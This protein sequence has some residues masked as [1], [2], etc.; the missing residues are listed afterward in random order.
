MIAVGSGGTLLAGQLILNHVS[1]AIGSDSLLPAGSGNQP[2]SEVT[3]PLN[4]LLAGLDYRAGDA[5]SETNQRAD[6]V[7]WVHIPRE[8]DRAYIV[9]LPRDLVVDIPAFPAAK[10]QGEKGGRLNASFAAGM[11]NKMGR[12]G[13]MQLLT[14]TVEQLTGVKFDMAGVIDWYGFTGITHELG[15]V[16]MCLD[17]GFKSTQPGFKNFTFD[18]GC[19]HYDEHKALALVRQRYDVEGGDYGR[20]K[21]QQQFI[22]QILKQATS[23][24][25]LS[26][27]LKLNAIIKSVGAS[28]KIDFGAYDFADLLWALKGITPD[29]LLTMRIPSS[30][31]G[32]ENNYG[33]EALNPQ[34]GPEMFRA[35]ADERIE[36]F[37]ASHPELA[38]RL[39]A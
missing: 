28:L 24:D 29:N 33:G 16:T 21:L 27:P 19:N 9:S 10:F 23:K 5:D 17:K 4:I 34:L 13:G 2:R 11:Q 37:L 6:S 1:D 30:T 26:N 3:G 12:P 35:M 14:K 39:P 25:V 31:I 22:K 7:M 36:L 32:N 18:A 38:S 8:H 20:Q 15:G